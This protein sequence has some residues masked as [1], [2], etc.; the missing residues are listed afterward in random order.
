MH[1]FSKSFQV[2]SI[3]LALAPGQVSS[4][5]AWTMTRI[6]EL[7]SLAGD[8]HFSKSSLHRA[9]TV[10][11]PCHKSEHI[12]NVKTAPTGCRMVSKLLDM[13]GI[14]GPEGS[15][16]CSHLQSTYHILTFFSRIPGTPNAL[17]LTL[18]TPHSWG[19][20]LLL[21]LLGMSFRSLV[22]CSFLL[23]FKKSGQWS[24][25]LESSVHICV[26]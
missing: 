22:A 20:A 3:L 14:R 7:I 21:P 10:I 17:K 16:F 19:F 5:L 23:I 24:L 15:D 18:V 13:E 8:C 11:F 6:Y 2:L 26:P 25:A 9:S 4:Y 12:T 1:F